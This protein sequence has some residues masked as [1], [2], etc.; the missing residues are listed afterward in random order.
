MTWRRKLLGL[1]VS[2]S[3]AAEVIHA[4]YVPLETRYL[5]Q[6]SSQSGVHRLDTHRVE[7][8]H[9]RSIRPLLN[10]SPDM[11]KTRSTLFK[12]AAA[13]AVAAGALFAAAS[14]SAANVAWSVG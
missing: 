14:A 6:L 7:Y 9:G 3:A 13:G 4:F 12:W 5:S 1:A 2:L 11:S 8:A 10:R